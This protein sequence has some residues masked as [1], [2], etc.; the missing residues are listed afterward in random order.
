MKRTQS[1]ALKLLGCYYPSIFEINY[2]EL[3]DIYGTDNE[4][5]LFHEYIHF[6]QDSTTNYGKLNICNFYNKILGIIEDIKANK[7]YPISVPVTLQK[8]HV[9]QDYERSE[10]IILGNTNKIKNN[11]ID[12]KFIQKEVP[13]SGG[14]QYVYC[15]GV[16]DKEYNIGAS[17]ILE[18]MAYLLERRLY[19][20]KDPAP[21]YPYKTIE[22][23]TSCLYPEFSKNQDLIIGLCELSLQFSNPAKFYFDSLYKIKNDKLSINQLDDLLKIFDADLHFSYMGNPMTTS[24]EV[25]KK[26][27]E[28]ALRIVKQFFGTKD[29]HNVSIYITTLFENALK[30]RLSDP[31]LITRGIFDQNAKAYYFLVLSTEIGYPMIFDEK[32]SFY[33]KPDAPSQVLLFTAIKEFYNIFVCGQKGCGLYQGCINNMK[34]D[35]KSHRATQECLKRPWKQA[36]LQKLCPLGMIIHLFGLSNKEFLYI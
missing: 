19:G 33:M 35:P 24:S 2:G 7:N 30:K 25:S 11:P 26:S 17:D 8:N 27:T 16:D 18:N 29:L 14:E 20:D 9:F 28:D 12:V 36:K 4:Y 34:Y 32:K 23:L 3:G 22:R 21:A 15:I 13:L 5:I 6:L 31:F 10:A 1:H